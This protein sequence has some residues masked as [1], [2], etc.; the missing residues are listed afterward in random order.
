MATTY[1][2]VLPLAGGLYSFSNSGTLNT[3]DGDDILTGT[4]SERRYSFFNSGR[5]NTGDG[6]DRISGTSQVTNSFSDGIVIRDG[7]IIDTGDGNDTITGTGYSN[8]ISLEN[9]QGII[10]T[11]KGDDVI[12]GTILGPSGFGLYFSNNPFNID[13]SV[14]N[15][16]TGEGNDV[17]SGNTSG[18]VG[19]VSTVP[20][21][22]GDGDDIITGTGNEVGFSCFSTL[23]TGDDN[24]IIAGSGSN[25]GINTNYQTIYDDGNFIY[26]DGSN[27]NTGDGNDTI[28]GTT[29]SEGGYGIRNS[30]YEGIIDTGNGSDIIIGIGSIGIY[31]DGSINTG[32]GKDSIIADG[33]FEGSGNVFLGNGKD[34]IKGFGNGNFNGGDGKDTMELTSGS[35]TIGISGT[36]V[37]F[38]KGSTIMKTYDFEILKA[39]DATYSI[40][41]LSDGQTIIVA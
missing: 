17:I 7:G 30:F 41:S 38:I 24:D 20:I 2:L 5:L 8:G 34:D 10:D 25:F 4:G 21:A 19:M 6:D 22:T 12:S 36:T 26:I 3:G 28:T 1:L 40:P 16:N 37:N 11:G 39:G 31:N 27:I 9:G 35:Y 33:G 29:T 23:N 13:T 32:D 18:G 14:F 15:I